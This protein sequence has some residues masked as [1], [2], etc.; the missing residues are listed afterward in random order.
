MH[1]KKINKHDQ[2]KK[3][4]LFHEGVIITMGIYKITNQMTGESYIGK[5]KDIEHRFK[6]HQNDLDEGTHHNSGLQEDYNNGYTL[7]FE[8]IREVNDSEEIDD[9]ERA[10]IARYNTFYE[11]YNNTPGG[12]YDEHKGKWDPNAKGRL[13][14]SKYQ[15]VEEMPSNYLGFISKNEIEDPFKRN[16]DMENA[17]SVEKIEIVNTE[18]IKHAEPLKTENIKPYEKEIQNITKSKD[19]ERISYL[20][21]ILYAIIILV[22]ICILLLVL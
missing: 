1:L 10:E 19:N 11:G 4:Q 8:I 14:S 22:L 13:P 17:D 3:H 7:L 6:W 5:S 2:H 12:E 20:E 15:P 9:D 18:N 21:L 16:M